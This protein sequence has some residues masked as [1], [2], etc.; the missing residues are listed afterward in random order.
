MPAMR[1]SLAT[2]LAV[3]FVF[4]ILNS[5]ESIAELRQVLAIDPED[6]G[7]HYTLMLNY[8]ALG[9]TDQAEREHRLY[10]RFK[11]DENAAPIGG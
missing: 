7:A 4:L 9:Q 2:V 1:L 11:A 10:L 6:L 8:W 5:D 3:G